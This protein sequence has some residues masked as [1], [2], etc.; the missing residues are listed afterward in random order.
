M[1]IL[2]GPAGCTELGERALQEVA[3]EHVQ[4]T[5]ARPEGGVVSPSTIESYADPLDWVMR[6]LRELRARR[7]PCA[8]LA[9]WDL[10]PRLRRPVVAQVASDRSAPPLRT[11]RV[12]RKRLNDDVRAQLGPFSASEFL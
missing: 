8:E 5:R 4:P 1:M 6:A 3:T 10:V 11:V 9:R 2:I 12:A 7:F